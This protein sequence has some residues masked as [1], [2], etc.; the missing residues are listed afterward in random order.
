[1]KDDY[2]GLKAI[3][4]IRKVLVEYLTRKNANP[5]RLAWDWVCLSDVEQEGL[6]ETVFQ[7]IQDLADRE[8]FRSP[9][10][11]IYRDIARD[12]K[13]AMLKER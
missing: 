2:Y 12:M 13:R 10:M 4:K 7:Y 1:M 3:E 6:T 9:Q 5:E 11:L 8:G